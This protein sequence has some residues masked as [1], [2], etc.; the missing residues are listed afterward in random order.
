MRRERSCRRWRAAPTAGRSPTPTCRPLLD[1]LRGGPDQQ[2]GFDA[3]IEPASRTAARRARSSCSASSAIRRTSRPDDASTASATSSWRR[4]CRSSCGAASRT[5]SCSIWPRADSSHDRRCSN[6][7]C[8]G[9]WPTRVRRRW[10]RNFAGQWLYLR[11]LPG[12]TPDLRCVPRL[13]RQPADRRSQRETELF[14]ESILRE[15]RSVARS[16][17][18]GLHVRQRAAGPALRDSQRQGQPLPARH[19]SRATARRGLLGQGSILTVTSYPHR[20]SPVLR[21]KWILE[22]LLGTPPPPPP[23]NVPRLKDTNAAGKVLSMRERMAQH[24]ANPV[25]ASCH[26][27]MDPPGFVARELRRR[28]AAADRGRA[29][30]ADRRVRRAARRHQVRRPGRASAG[31]ARARPSS[32]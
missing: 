7:R 2:G 25:C 5:T 20:T 18:G 19:A 30:R 11:N 28:R 6:G 26:S 22:N 8:G 4:A 27:M 17:D 10:S 14:F 16:V 24:R 15:D 12:L 21:G 1:V 23:P 13:R 31:A 32:S 29:L 9:C 3:G